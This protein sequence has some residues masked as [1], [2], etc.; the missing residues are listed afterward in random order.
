M[1]RIPPDLHRHLS[2]EAAE[3]RVILNRLIAD[4]LSRSHL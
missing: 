4:K 3:S 2:V 1:V